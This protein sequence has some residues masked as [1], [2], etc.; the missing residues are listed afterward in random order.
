M[1]EGEFAGRYAEGGWDGFLLRFDGGGVLLWNTVFGSVSD[2]FVRGVTVDDAGQFAYVYGSFGSMY[3]SVLFDGYISSGGIDG[4]LMKFRN[5]GLKNWTYVLDGIGYTSRIDGC[6]IDEDGSL[7]LSAFYASNSSDNC[8]QIN[9][10]YVIKLSEEKSLFWK[11]LASTNIFPNFTAI[12]YGM[13]RSFSLFSVQAQNC[14]NNPRSFFGLV[15]YETSPSCNSLTIGGSFLC[16]PGT[17]SNNY[18]LTNVSYCRSCEPGMYCNTD[19]L[20]KPTGYCSGGFFCK[21]G[22]KDATGSSCDERSLVC[23]EVTCSHLDSLSCGGECEKGF[24]CPSG[25]SSPLLCPAGKYCAYARATFPTGNCS[26]GYYCGALGNDVFQPSHYNQS[27]GICPPGTYCPSGTIFPIPCPPGTFSNSSQNV[28]QEQCLL[29]PPGHFCPSQRTIVPQQCE[30]GYYCPK[31]MIQANPPSNICPKGAYCK[32]GSSHPMPCPSGEYND[33]LQQSDC[34]SC[35]PRLTCPFQ[36]MTTP[37]DCPAGHY[38]PQNNSS[39]IPCPKGS[40][41]AT[42]NLASEDECTACPPGKY[43][44]TSGLQSPTGDCFAGHMCLQGAIYPNET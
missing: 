15:V 32:P 28:Q 37:N 35:P 16:P 13:N 17:F 40:L 5:D 19:G 11:R 10:L 41:S 26:A 7:Y 24:F 33:K 29:C 1:Y 12:A 4:F 2:E 20:S 31:G 14:I 44:G 9:S 38:C 34:R 36:N 8:S 23:N 18:G 22:S 3:Q 30:Q 42:Q 27:T 43:C 39:P 6:A 25:S 21:G